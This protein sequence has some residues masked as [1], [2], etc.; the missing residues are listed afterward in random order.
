MNDLNALTDSILAK[1]RSE[2]EEIIKN[3]QAEADRIT[4][5]AEQ[6]AK[7]TRDKIIDNY[8][9]KADDLEKSAKIRVELENRKKKLAVKHALIEKAFNQA[10]SALQNLPAEKRI[11]F[12]T[13]R[14]ASAGMAGGGEVIVSKD[15]SP[16]AEWSSIVKVANEIIARSG[17]LSQ[18]SLS[19][20]KANFDGGFLLKGPGFEINASYQAI[21]DQVKESLVPEI[22]DVLFGKEEG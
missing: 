15:S 19:K 13:E 4:S 18:I 11:R 1:A 3:A 10:L 9:R 6:K 12:L 7:E 21:L 20:E 17:K 2:A 14:L 8:Q 5:E 22:A 16:A